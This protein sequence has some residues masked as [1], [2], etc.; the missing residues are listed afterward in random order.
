[1]FCKYSGKR[2][3]ILQ[4]AASRQNSWA[5]LVVVFSPTNDQQALC[6]YVKR[7]E[8]LSDEI[9]ED[10]KTANNKKA[11]FEPYITNIS[12]SNYTQKVLPWPPQTITHFSTFWPDL[13]GFFH[14]HEPPFLQSTDIWRIQGIVVTHREWPVLAGYSCSSFNV[15]AGLLAA[16]L[17]SCSLVLFLLMPHFIDFLMTAFQFFCTLLQPQQWDPIRP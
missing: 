1:M 13:G 6:K 10:S 8:R 2:Y 9:A 15:A 3:W 16:S 17:I 14:E 7:G 11:A 4:L 5:C 12:A